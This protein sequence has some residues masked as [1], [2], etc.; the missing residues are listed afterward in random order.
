MTVPV[1]YFF[2]SRR[3]PTYETFYGSPVQNKAQR[4][5]L[6]YWYYSSVAKRRTKVPAIFRAI[7]RN[8][9]GI[10]IVFIHIFRD[11]SRKPVWEKLKQAKLHNL[12][13]EF[14]FGLEDN[15]MS[16]DSRELSMTGSLPGRKP[17]GHN[18]RQ[19][20]TKP[21][22]NDTDSKPKTD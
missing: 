22:F 9:H 12:S 6:A 3:T 16:Y 14:S 1:K 10:F 19:L 2:I 11:F 5:L 8:F 13:Q 7:L 21:H 18:L 17:G 20:L 4:Q 15:N